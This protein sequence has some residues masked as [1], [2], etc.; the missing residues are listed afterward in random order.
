MDWLDSIKEI[1]KAQEKNQLVMFVGAGVSANSGIPTWGNLID[2]IAK[3]IGYD[4]CSLCSKKPQNCECSHC[5]HTFSQ[6][7]YLKIPEYFYQRTSKK[8]YYSFLHNILSANNGPNPINDEIVRILPSHIITTNY[9]SLIESSKDVN[10]QLY[11][12]VSQDS[13]LLSGSG[14]RYI[15]KMHGDIEKPETIV[16]KESDYLNYE[17]N[18]ILISTFIKSLLINHT[19]VF[20]GYSLNDYNLNLIIGWINYFRKIHGV[21]NS[22]K[23]I[24]LTSKSPGKF[25]KKRLKEKNIEVVNLDAVPISSKMNI[26]VSITHPSA[27]KLYSYLRYISDEKQLQQVVSMES[28]LSEKYEI[29][30][31]YKR[32]SFCDLLALHQLGHTEMI[33]SV[34]FLYDVEQYNSLSSI[35]LTGSSDITDY[36]IKAGISS[37]ACPVANIE[38]HSSN[39]DDEFMF[40]AYL[41]N[42]YSELHQNL[43][44]CTSM[45]EKAYYSSLLGQ[46]SETVGKILTDDFTLRQPNDYIEIILHKIRL[47][48][49]AITLFDRK[50]EQADEIRRLLDTA[51]SIYKEALSFTKKIANSSFDEIILER[52]LVDLEKKYKYSTNTWYSNGTLTDLQ[53]IQSYVYD[54]YFFFK[55]NALP[56]DYFSETRHYFS[57]YIKAI[58]C[59]CSPTEPPLRHNIFGIDTRRDRYALNEIDVDI[60]VKYCKATDFINWAEKY[61]VQH[62]EV[63]EGIDIIKKFS[64]LCMSYVLFKNRKWPEQIKVFLVLLSFI[65]LTESNKDEIYNTLANMIETIA[66]ETPKLLL[67]N[68]DTIEYLF[69]NIKAQNSGDLKAKMVRSL[70]KPEIYPSIIQTNENKFSNIIYSLSHF[71]DADT[72]QMLCDSID[73]EDNLKA[74]F[75]KV[76]FFRKILPMGKYIPLIERSIS[77]LSAGQI[78]HLVIE[79]FLPYSKEVFDVFFNIISTEAVRRE[80]QP[81]IMMYPDKIR[82]NIDNLLILCLLNFDVDLSKLSKFTSYSEHLEFMLNPNTF[83]YSKVDTSDYMW[84]NLIF[85][86]KYQNHFIAHKEELL[87]GPLEKVFQMKV[88]T[89]AQQKIVYGLLIDRADLRQF[90]KKLQ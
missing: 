8:E 64:N 47:R 66:E 69:R 62:I 78:F 20:V 36:F 56:Y 23:N 42:N 2:A 52:H 40:E 28:I 7:E 63:A 14:V 54:Y 73:K 35:L 82:E 4:K 37:I 1:K 34:L 70:L 84:E 13:E 88:E 61:S 17:Q 57:Y 29:L 81:G 87:A 85:S 26:P 49:I 48:L 53:K 12:V 9:D 3:K 43:E 76:F 90:G 59:T 22:P 31:S 89:R 44:Y 19:F 30:K 51:P 38:I 55:G 11:T 67:E 83:D 77:E 21:K 32:I 27:Q 68:I 10:A 58:L 50:P 15:I 18:H 60:I 65:K 79:R 39:S 5:N 80:Q 86:D 75:K 33:G 72:L 45:S 25:E 71:I 74:K 6:E 41:D 24:F 46:D 16:L